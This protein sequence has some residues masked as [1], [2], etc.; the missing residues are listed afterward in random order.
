MQTSLLDLPVPK[1]V[2][3]SLS[4]EASRAPY[5]RLWRTWQEVLHRHSPGASVD[6]NSCITGTHQARLNKDCYSK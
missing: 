6:S 5:Q 4:Q 1:Q 2:S 3:K